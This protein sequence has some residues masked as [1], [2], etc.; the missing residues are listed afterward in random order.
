MQ[1][2]IP[3]DWKK[4]NVSAIFKK[5]AKSLAENYRPI[6]LTSLV[7]KL[8]E[9]FVKD[10]ILSHL[11]E[12]KL[13]SP[14][15]F[16]FLSGRCTTTQ[17][18]NYLNKCIGKMVNGEVVDCIYLD[19]AKAF[20]TVPHKRLLNKLKA[21]GITGSMLTWIQAFLTGR[22]HTVVVNG[23]SSETN[24]VI[25]GIPQGSVLGPILFIVYINDILDNVNS[26]VFLFA[27]DIEIL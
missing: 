3:D 26:N 20:D 27:D 7:C 24:A 19:F 11:L 6:S 16:G 2:E 4:A 23:V 25:S 10:A 13:L 8:M 14:K 21:Y 22:T 9:T 17:L 5:G 1:G 12:N 18:L 15:Q